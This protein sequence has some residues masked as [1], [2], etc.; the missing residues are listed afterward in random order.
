MNNT[1]TTTRH[2][3][4]HLARRVTRAYPGSEYDFMVLVASTIMVEVQAF[5][6][7]QAGEIAEKDL[8]GWEAYY[9]EPY[10]GET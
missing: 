5:N 8:P 2:F 3:R 6:E 1:D 9:S 10:W 7:V 4:V